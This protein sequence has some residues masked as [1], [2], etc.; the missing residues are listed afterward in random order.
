LCVCTL[1]A[2]FSSRD[3][4]WSLGVEGVTLTNAQAKRVLRA[5]TRTGSQSNKA[6]VGSRKVPG[7][8]KFYKEGE[9]DESGVDFF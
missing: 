3:A 5:L 4:G 7:G 8:D 2:C 1:L 9:C 6:S